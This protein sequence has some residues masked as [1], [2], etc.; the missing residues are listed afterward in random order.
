MVLTPPK[1]DTTI[2]SISSSI[3]SINSSN[4][5]NINSNTT[6]STSNTSNSSNPNDHICLK[7]HQLYLILSPKFSIILNINLPSCIHPQSKLLKLELP[8][9]KPIVKFLAFKLLEFKALMFKALKFTALRFKTLEFKALESKSPRLSFKLLQFKLLR[10]RIPKFKRLLLLSP[11]PSLMPLRHRL[12]KLPNSSTHHSCSIR[13]HEVTYP[14]HT[15]GRVQTPPPDTRWLQHT[16]QGQF[17]LISRC[18]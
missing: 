7:S 10:P 8:N 15:Q 11:I 1:M 16:H 13:L 17:R 12:P 5:T 18:L 3:N 6:R 9:P 4:T 2:S 14:K